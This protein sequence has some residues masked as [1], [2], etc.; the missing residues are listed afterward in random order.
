[1][2]VSYR[3]DIRHR[4]GKEDTKAD[5]ISRALLSVEF[6]DEVKNDKPNYSQ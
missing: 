6:D 4:N 2:T 3:I 5:A 1:M